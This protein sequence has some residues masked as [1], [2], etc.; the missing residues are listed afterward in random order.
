MSGAS[1]KIANNVSRDRSSG[2]SA[3]RQSIFGALHGVGNID[4]YLG[5]ATILAKG[6]NDTL[7]S[8]ST[9]IGYSSDNREAY[10]V[11]RAGDPLDA[12]LRYFRREPGAESVGAFRGRAACNAR[13][14]DLAR[15]LLRI[16]RHSV[17]GCVSFPM[18]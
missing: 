8:F 15:P 16:C 3:R 17:A 18:P 11:G 4:T 13:L 14:Y 10:R 2:R 5:D 6:P 1:I 12:G 9:M 7:S